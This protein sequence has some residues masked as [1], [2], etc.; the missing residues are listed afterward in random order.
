MADRRQI[1][2]V[3]GGGF[4]ASVV[5]SIAGAVLVTIFATIWADDVAFS[6]VAASFVAG[7]AAAA[8]VAVPF[9]LVA[10]TV[11]AAWI[12]RRARFI[13]GRRLTI[14]SAI[15]GAVL[16]LMFPLMA[17]MGWGTVRQLFA[18]APIV[19]PVGATC[20]LVFVWLLRRTK[21]AL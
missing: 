1:S 12:I 17:V 8:I 16:A 20:G 7:L 21:P 5:G 13:R 6:D 10:G 4:L 18:S 9:G 19:A 2:L 15:T 3:A 14:E 11:G